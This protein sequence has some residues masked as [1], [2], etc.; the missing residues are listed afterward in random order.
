MF[1]SMSTF[2]TSLSSMKDSRSFSNVTSKTLSPKLCRFF[3]SPAA[4]VLAADSFVYNSSF[5]VARVILVYLL[6]NGNTIP[7]GFE[8]WELAVLNG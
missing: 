7:S 4:A 2:K 1:P 5:V 8:H 3:G 6:L